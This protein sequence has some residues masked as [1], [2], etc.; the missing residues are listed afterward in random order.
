MNKSFKAEDFWLC[1]GW[2]SILIKGVLTKLDL[3]LPFLLS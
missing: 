2:H 1:K 3:M